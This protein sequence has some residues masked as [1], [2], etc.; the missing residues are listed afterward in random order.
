MPPCRGKSPVSLF[1]ELGIGLSVLVMLMIA[2][3]CHIAVK[4]LKRNATGDEYQG[5]HLHCS[6]SCAEPPP[7]SQPPEAQENKQILS[8][9]CRQGINCRAFYL[10]RRFLCS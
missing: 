4:G 3:V 9:G 7:R 2:V 6:C 8:E 10:R 5:V 1:V